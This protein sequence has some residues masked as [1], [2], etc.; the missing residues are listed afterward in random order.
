MV[1]FSSHNRLHHHQGVTLVE[2]AM[3]MMIVAVLSVG[4]SGMVKTGVEHQLSER[5]VQ[6]MRMMA[7]NLVDDLRYDLRTADT[8]NKLGSGSNILVITTANNQKITYQLDTATHRMTRKSST[9]P[10]TKI[11]NDPGAFAQNMQFD[12][13]NGNASIP[14]FDTLGTASDGTPKAV[15][16]H[17]VTVTA[18]LPASGASTALDAA[19]GPPSFRL[20]EFTFNIAAA[21]EFR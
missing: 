5:Q 8:V 16:L 9:S 4:V 11:Y 17:N 6:T 14:C 13:K 19:F 1:L 2:L 12:C 20:N 15:V 21:T 18:A 7:M 10:A 3:S